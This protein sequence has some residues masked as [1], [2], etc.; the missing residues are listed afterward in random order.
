MVFLAFQ[1]YFQSYLIAF[2]LLSSKILKITPGLSWNQVF[3]RISPRKLKNKVLFQAKVFCQKD[4]NYDLNRL[5]MI[6]MIIGMILMPS[7][8][9]VYTDISVDKILS[10]ILSKII[11]W[12]TSKA[13]RAISSQA[14]HHC[15]WQPI[16]LSFKITVTINPI[17]WFS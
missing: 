7:H 10:K 17:G 2:R 12:T 15:Y 16:H 5:P 11:T 9:T 8:I 1:P 6:M 14:K 4:N 13:Q 3:R